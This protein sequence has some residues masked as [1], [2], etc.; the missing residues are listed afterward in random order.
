GR[1]RQVDPA[2]V[3]F[4]G[5]PVV[6]TVRVEAEQ[7][8]PEAVLAAGGAVAAPLV[9]AGPHKDRH[10]VALEADGPVGLGVLPL[11]G[12]RHR[13]AGELHLHLG[14]PVGQRRQD[15]LVQL[16][17]VG[18]GERDLGFGGDVAGK[19]VGVG[20]LDDERLPTAGGQQ[21]HVGRVDGDAGGG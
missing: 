17:Q 9:A 5:E 20:R 21:V 16:G 6:V 2:A 10:H 7:G 13:P 1:Q 14:G 8:Q 18:V 15:V 3:K 12:N 11:H 19:A 4:A